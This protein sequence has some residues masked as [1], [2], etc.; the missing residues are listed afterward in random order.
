MARLSDFKSDFESDA[1]IQATPYVEAQRATRKRDGAQVL[2]RRHLRQDAA[3]RAEREVNLT[4]RLAG[5]P[6]VPELVD[7]DTRDDPPWVALAPTEGTPLN[8][9]LASGPL[10]LAR[11]LDLGC[12]LARALRDLHS[13][14]YIHSG[15]CSDVVWIGRDGLRAQLVGFEMVRGIGEPDAL[16]S[17]RLAAT[18][19]RYA[20]PERTGRMGRGSDH[21]SDL[22]STGALLYHALL[23]R[24]PFESDDPLAL[25]HAQM[26]RLPERPDQVRPEIPAALSRIVCRL[27]EKEPE[28]RYASADVLLR[29]LERCR[30]L[31][32]SG[33]DSSSAK[34]PSE[35]EIARLLRQIPLVGR[36]NELSALR[37]AF[38]RARSSHF[39]SLLVSGAPGIGKSSLVQ[40]IRTPVAEADGF[41]AAGSF[42]ARRFDRPYSGFSQL[43]GSLTAQ[44]LSQ[45][46]SQLEEMRRTVLD[47]LGTLAPALVS[48]APELAHILP[49]V[50]PLPPLG[51]AETLNQ[52][53][54]ALRRFLC[55]VASPERPIV[56]I[57]EAL[58]WAD[59]GSRRLLRDLVLHCPPAAPL[60][61][62]ATLEDPA[63]IEHASERRSALVRLID[64]LTTGSRPARTLELLPLTD[65]D[66]EAILHQ[67]LGSSEDQ[68]TELARILARKS[69]RIPLLLQSLIADACER[70]FVRRDGD[71]GWIVDAQEV[72]ALALQEDSASLLGR[73]VGSLAPELLRTLTFASIA[74]T[75]FDLATL[76]LVAEEPREQLQKRLIGLCSE[77]LLI[78]EQARFRFAHP[79]ILEAAR[80]QLSASERARL[81]LKLGQRL[82]QAHTD[83][84]D[85]EVT[86][87]IA[88][89]INAGASYL[90]DRGDRI[91][92][93]ANLRAGKRALT[94]GAA[95]TALG[96]L[97]TCAHHFSTEDW[98]T[99]QN[100]GIEIHLNLVEALLQLHRFE[101][102]FEI[103]AALEQRPLPKVRRAELEV[104]RIQAHIL[105]GTSRMQLV[106]ILRQTLRG[107]EIKIPRRPSL[108]RTRLT[109][110]WTDVWLRR[111][112]AQRRFRPM[113][114]RDEEKEVLAILLLGIASSVLGAASPRYACW[115]TSRLLR[116][117]RQEGYPGSPS[118]TLAGYA[119]YRRSAF[120]RVHGSDRIAD[121]ALE[122]TEI[123]PHPLLTPRTKFITL[124]FVRAWT[125]PRRE[126]VAEFATIAG[127]FRELGDVQYE[128]YSRAY[129]TFF[130]AI[131]GMPLARV[132]PAFARIAR[133]AR[134]SGRLASHFS[135][136]FSYL[137]DQIPDTATLRATHTAVLACIESDVVSQHAGSW[138]I[139]AEALCMLDRYDEFWE[140]AEFVAPWLD[141]RGALA[142]FVGDFYFFRGIVACA[143]I[144]RQKRRRRPLER[145]LSRG[146]KK[147]GLW[148]KDGGSDFAHMAL[149]LDAEQARARGDSGRARASYL[150]ASALAEQVGYVHHA[151]LL[152]RRLASLLEESRAPGAGDARQRAASLYRLWGATALADSLTG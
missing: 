101:H 27:L 1:C 44:L 24:P 106:E 68:V 113:Q 149:G 16:H 121:A 79:R 73:H 67:A 77:G 151:A 125:H 123:A 9:I 92:I 42:D 71:R 74:G 5:S 41:L 8:D 135:T 10:E 70:G 146:R 97:E 75:S 62:L 57:L 137:I 82:M 102:S 66:C 112:L 54:L 12:E 99:R 2:L 69:R 120:G 13:H 128:Y 52:L 90:T 94:S 20:S 127:E 3:D 133:V 140:L 122:W 26:A 87:A 88:N 60:L 50:G 142:C 37:T 6:N 91:Q 83:P 33:E 29:D 143:L 118:T 49:D 129:H 104:K 110:L 51:P 15:L 19:L 43:L 46:E 107:F 7:F 81:H 131:T 55:S 139:W 108:L 36:D 85:P 56:L 17:S 22:Y 64:T 116:Q 105:S 138:V 25:I 114:T 141:D 11:V 48:L 47:A 152:Q 98:E 96:Y 28:A 89:H 119:A 103:L 86:F 150:E 95:N 109:V 100:E 80:D 111:L 40:S 32:S 72:E 65:E 144:H 21:R 130:S 93:G 18:V 14:G 34:L 147:L 132:A 4:T 63:T 124:N 145:A 39:T 38:E 23:G 148:I 84:A 134:F 61:L 115:V 45:S 59:A 136:C 76:Q 78:A 30:E 126:L 35:S 53:S 117:F 58:E 31:V